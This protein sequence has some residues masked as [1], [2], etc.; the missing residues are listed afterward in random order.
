MRKDVREFIGV[1]CLC[2]F[3]AFGYRAVLGGEILTQSRST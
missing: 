2:S 1:A 3:L